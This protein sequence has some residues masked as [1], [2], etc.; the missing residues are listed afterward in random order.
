MVSDG[1][2]ICF[3]KVSLQTASKRTIRVAGQELHSFSLVRYSC[4][5]KIESHTFDK[6]SNREPG[7]VLQIPI[8]TG[9]CVCGYESW[10]NNGY[11]NT[12]FSVPPSY[13]VLFVIGPDGD[14]IMLSLIGAV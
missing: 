13:M 4:R 8:L 9:R 3:N 12:V 2:E 5:L 10:S 11:T 6:D 7:I 14:E 1:F